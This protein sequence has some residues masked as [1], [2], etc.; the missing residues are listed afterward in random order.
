MTAAAN[1]DIQPNASFA[2][3][4]IRQTQKMANAKRILVVAGSD[5]SGGA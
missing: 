1:L 3:F 5:S 4:I 2:Q